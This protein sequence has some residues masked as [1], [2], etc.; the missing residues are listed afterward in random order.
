MTLTC[1]LFTCPS[2]LNLRLNEVRLQLRILLL[3]DIIY[4]YVGLDTLGVRN[5]MFCRHVNC[6][7]YSEYTLL[8]LLHSKRILITLVRLQ[9]ILLFFFFCVRRVTI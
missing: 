4:L 3:R 8:P 6:S 2:T 7:L 1:R 5:R 9:S